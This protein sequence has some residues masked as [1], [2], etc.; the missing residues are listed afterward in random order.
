MQE[1]RK[2]SD[3]PPGSRERAGEAH[4]G[5]TLLPSNFPEGQIRAESQASPA[6]VANGILHPKFQAE[7]PLGP[8]L[9]IRGAAALASR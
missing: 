9:W 6:A 3:R 4:H 5:V 8:G 7:R 1:G 2:D